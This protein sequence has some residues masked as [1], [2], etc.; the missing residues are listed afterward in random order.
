MRVMKFRLNISSREVRICSTVSLLTSAAEVWPRTAKPMPASTIAGP[1]VVTIALMWSKRSASAT[2]GATLVV[3]DSGDILSP[4][5]APETTA[6][7][8][9][10]GLMPRPM[11]T[12][13]SATPTVPAVDQEEPVAI[14]VMM[15]AIMAVSRNQLGLM[16]FRPQK[17]IMGTVPPA[18][19]EP[20]RAPMQ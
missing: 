18:I 20:I 1:P 12:P 16:S 2:A 10:A 13:I 11:P 4:K 7:A 14:A 15:Q 9:S 3:S 17:M 19:Q 6:P 8:V 5:A